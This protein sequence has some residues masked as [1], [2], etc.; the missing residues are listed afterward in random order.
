LVEYKFCLS[1]KKAQSTLFELIL[2]SSL[3]DNERE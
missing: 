3:I 1:G 2:C